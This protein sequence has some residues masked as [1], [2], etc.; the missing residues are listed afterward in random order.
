M[1]QVS[2]SDICTV[3]LRRVAPGAASIRLAQATIITQRKAAALTAIYLDL[4]LHPSQVLWEALKA[5]PVHYGKLS[6]T[7]DA[8]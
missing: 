2:N 7:F 1:N 8:H 6:E 5:L 4:M 3:Y